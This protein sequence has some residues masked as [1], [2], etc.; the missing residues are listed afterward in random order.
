MINII[1]V[2]IEMFICYT[3]L[4]ILFK[5]YRI[6]GIYI[7][8]IISTIVSLVMIAKEITILGINIPLGFSTI[9]SLI[10]GGNLLTQLRGQEE[11]KKYL[12]VI[13]LTFM[14]SIIFI[15]TSVLFENSQYNLVTNKS[16]NQI[17]ENNFRIYISFLISIVFSIYIINKIYY[18]LKR[19]KNKIIISNIFSIII[20]EF[21][22]NIIYVLLGY[23]FE[24]SPIE[25]VLCIILRYIIKT[26][27]GIFGTIPLYL[28]VKNI[29]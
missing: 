25:I 21:F 16:Y 23:L 5:K 2:I 19:L 14:I 3:S 29:E 11:L 22:E 10:I 1:L 15:N 12:I 17:F 13:I 8:A 24:Y 18:L 9:T 6:E 20:V 4:L 26:I 28:A 7:Y 27:I